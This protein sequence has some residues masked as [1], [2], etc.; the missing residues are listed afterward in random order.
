MIT[1]Y[2]FADLIIAEVK[3]VTGLAKHLLHSFVALPGHIPREDF[4][5]CACFSGALQVTCDPIP[6]QSLLLICLLC[7]IVL[8]HTLLISLSNFIN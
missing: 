4:P 2:M 7:F 6:Y 5:A 1:A 3:S 8:S